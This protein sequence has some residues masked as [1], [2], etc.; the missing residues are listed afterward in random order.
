MGAAAACEMKTE[1]PEQKRWKKMTSALG[2]VVTPHCER[3]IQ[4]HFFFPSHLFVAMVTLVDM[5][6][7]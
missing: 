1:C 4:L 7:T 2:P 5:G 6:T 3:E